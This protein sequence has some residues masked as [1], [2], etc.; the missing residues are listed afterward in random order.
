MFRVGHQV[1]SQDAP[2]IK[3][4]ICV[5]VAFSAALSCVVACLLQAFGAQVMQLYTRHERILEAAHP[6]M[7]GV[8]L[9][10][11]PCS[12]ASWAGCGQRVCSSGA[13]TACS[14]GTTRWACPSRTASA[15]SSRSGF[16]ASGWGTWRRSRARPS[17]AS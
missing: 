11:P 14:C 10:V 9:S 16:S 17:P 12:C 2:G 6:A 5:C 8:A 1:G 4:S 7:L 13:R 3:R 15:S